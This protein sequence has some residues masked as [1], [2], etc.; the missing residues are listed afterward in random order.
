MGSRVDISSTLFGSAGTVTLIQEL[1][2]TPISITMVN[3]GWFQ[4]IHW[5][6]AK[7]RRIGKYF[8]A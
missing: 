6:R 5:C 8:Y 4:K 2:Y 1:I 7:D 3:D